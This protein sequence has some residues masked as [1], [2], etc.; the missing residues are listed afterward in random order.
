[1]SDQFP[2][3]WGKLSVDDRISFCLA[4]ARRMRKI[5]SL[6][7]DPAAKEHGLELA[8]RWD[9]LAFELAKQG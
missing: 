9:V 2:D 4:M 8:T 6:T 1:M 7:T 3:D 5:A